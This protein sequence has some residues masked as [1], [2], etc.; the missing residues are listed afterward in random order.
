MVAADCDGTPV[1][2]AGLDPG[3]GSYIAGTIGFSM[4]S[5]FVQC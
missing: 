4:A 3:A 5:I 2:V 1:L